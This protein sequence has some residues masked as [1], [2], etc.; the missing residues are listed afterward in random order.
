MSRKTA[1]WRKKIGSQW[2]GSDKKTLTSGN[3][4]KV[5]G[6]IPT[7]KVL[8]KGLKGVYNSEKKYHEA[9]KASNLVCSLPMSP[10]KEARIRKLVK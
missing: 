4:G 9:G 10:E 8:S 2:T 5:D 3:R 6:L 1:E 7:Q